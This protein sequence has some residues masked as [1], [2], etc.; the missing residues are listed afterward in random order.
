MSE[1]KWERVEKENG[2]ALR[3]KEEP[4][5]A[6][7][8]EA[9]VFIGEKVEGVYVEKRTG[10]GENL[11]AM[12]MVKTEE[13]GL[14]GIWE[15]AVLVDR[16]EP[17][18]VGSDIRLAISSWRTSKTGKE[19]PDFDLDFRRPAMESSKKANPMDDIKL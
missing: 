3:W 4:T 19:Y 11:S 13:H 17:V 16:F 15:T 12:Y 5:N 10:L 7:Q 9:T 6:K 18:P 14:V 2:K 1:E 8:K